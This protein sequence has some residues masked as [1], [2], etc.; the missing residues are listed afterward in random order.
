M[1]AGC[2]VGAERELS[3]V[4]GQGVVDDSVDVPRTD[5]GDRRGIPMELALPFLEGES[6]E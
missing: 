1:Y 6:E 2:R 4:E 5:R 3:D